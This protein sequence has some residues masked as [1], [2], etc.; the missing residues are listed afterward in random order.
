MKITIFWNVAL[1]SLIEIGRSFSSAYC[2]HRQSALMMQAVSNAETSA[3]FYQTT[4]CNNTEDSHLQKN[5]IMNWMGKLIQH[6]DCTTG[7]QPAPY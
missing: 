3:N 4:E 1:C 5:T 6:G 2:L 7:V